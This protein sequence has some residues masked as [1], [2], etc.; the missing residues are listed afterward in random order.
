MADRTMLTAEEQLAL[1]DMTPQLNAARDIIDR[2]KKIGTVDVT[3]QEQRLQAVTQTREGLLQ[4]F[5]QP[6]VQR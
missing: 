5:G 3:E 2:L 6:I 4:Q 1:R